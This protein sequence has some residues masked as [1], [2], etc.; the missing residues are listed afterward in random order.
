ME[1]QPKVTAITLG[2][3]SFRIEWLGKLLPCLWA[4]KAESGRQRAKSTALL[5]ILYNCSFW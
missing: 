1:S 4:S 2:R 3:L 5:E